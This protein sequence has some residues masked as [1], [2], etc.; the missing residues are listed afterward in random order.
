MAERMN[1][2]NGTKVRVAFEAPPGQEPDFSMVCTF[3]RQLDEASFL[4]S[5]PLAAGTPLPLDEGRKLL[6]RYGGPGPE[7]MILAG[8]ADDVVREGIRLCWRVRRVA[9]PRRYFRRAD[10]RLQVSLRLQYRQDTWPL[11]SDGRI[12]WE[13]GLSLDISN[14]GIAFYLSSFFEVGEVC[15][16]SLPRV[17]TA[18]AGQGIRDMVGVVCWCRQ[19]PSHSPLRNVC[20]LQFRFADAAEREALADY[21]AHIKKSFAL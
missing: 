12:P 20:G 14:G 17:G 2:K 1:I 21:V 13:D 4:L 11:G 8:Y 16:L 5:V 7:A 3:Y 15:R 6:I 9:A 10:E 19:A 18:P